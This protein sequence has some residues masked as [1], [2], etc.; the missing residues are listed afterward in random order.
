MLIQLD[1]SHHHWLGEGGPKFALLF[2]VDYATG[3]VVDGLFCGQEDSLSYFRLFQG[4]I[5]RRGLPWP[6]IPTATPSSNTAQNTSPPGLPPS[7]AGPWRNWE[8]D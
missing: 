2:A 8:Y 5:Q 6:C 3:A 4:L 1:G 7:S